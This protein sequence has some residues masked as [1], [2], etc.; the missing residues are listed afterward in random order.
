MELSPYPATA[1]DNWRVAQGATS[2][3][4]GEHLEVL[5]REANEEYRAQRYAN[6]RKR[7]QRRVQAAVYRVSSPVDFTGQLADG[8]K[9]AL[10]T[11]AM[12]RTSLFRMERAG[13]SLDQ[14]RALQRTRHLGG[15]AFVLAYDRWL[16]MAWILTDLDALARGMAVRVRSTTVSGG[17]THYAPL[18]PWSRRPDGSRW[19][20]YL[21]TA[22]AACDDARGALP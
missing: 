5:I 7:S 12:I 21:P 6:I 22:I 11:K 14:L 1:M 8:R 16:D 10:E 4:T 15:V 2:R 18:V 20:D 19:L 13:G 17:I 9:V 3:A